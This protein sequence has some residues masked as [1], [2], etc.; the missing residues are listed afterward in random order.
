V[1]RSCDGPRPR[2]PSDEF[3]S[4]G[5]A[6]SFTHVALVTHHSGEWRNLADAQDSGS[7]VRKDVGVQVPPR[8]PL[9]TW[10]FAKWADLVAAMGI[11]YG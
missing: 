5:P 9:L 2:G 10:G 8:P 7:C 11:R 4:G 6:G 1:T 3:S